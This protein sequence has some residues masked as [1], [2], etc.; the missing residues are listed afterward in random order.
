[1]AENAGN[2]L[3]LRATESSTGDA[4][5]GAAEGFTLVELIFVCAVISI[6]AAIAVPTVFRSKLAANETAAVGTL[7]TVHTGQLTYTLTCGYGLFASSFIDLGDPAGDGFLPPELTASVE[8]HK[9]GYKYLLEPGPTGVSGLIDC[10]GAPT[11]LDYYVR[12]VPIGVGTTGV[13]GFASNQGIAIWQDS[14]GDPPIEPFE[15]GPTVSA[16][17]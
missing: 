12:A 1:M 10:H 17:E 9:S 5:L 13:R 16:I 8:P 6:L 11:A 14:T 15:P 2:P 4:R 7:R 3:E